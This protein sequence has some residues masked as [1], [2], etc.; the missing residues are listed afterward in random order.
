MK[1]IPPG[2]ENP[3]IP[4]E[5]LSVNDALIAH[6]ISAARACFLDNNLG[7]LT[8]GKLA[9]FVVLSTDSWEDF[10]TEGS[11]SVEATYL[12]GVQAYG[13]VKASD[14]NA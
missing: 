7:S 13:Q 5:R 2:W 6:T 9:D 14:F 3:W 10:A 11:A 12:S 1:R 8:P 4:S